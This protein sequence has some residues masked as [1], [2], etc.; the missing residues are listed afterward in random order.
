MKTYFKYVILF[1]A[2][3]TFFSCDP[4]EDKSNFDKD[5][6]SISASDLKAA[7]SCTQLPNQDGKVIGD[8]YVIIKNNRPDIGGVWHLVHG[9]TQYTYGTDND[10][11]ICPAN[12][13]YKLYYVGISAN[14]VVQTEPFTFNVTNVFDEYDKY[15]TGAKDKSDKTAK[16]IWKFRVV[17]WGSVCNMGAHGGW[18][19]TDAGYTPESNFAWWNNVSSIDKI[20]DQSMS[21][22]YDGGKLLTYKPNGDS[23]GSGSFSYT[24]NSPEKGVIGELVTSIP[25]IGHE[26]DDEGQNNTKNTFWILTLTDN[27]MTL[28]HP[29]KYKGGVDWDDSGWYVYYEAK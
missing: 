12:G 27:Y 1:A 9:D 25:V 29:D 21:M 11:I 14:K 16:K 15:L 26:H 6:T 18:K 5:G 19:Y 13:D 2:A 17:A 3:V 23:V 8:Q 20:G 4:L 7:L 28:Y 24:H 22:V 10:T